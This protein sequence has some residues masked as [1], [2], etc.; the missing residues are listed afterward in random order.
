V[1]FLGGFGAPKS[2]GRKP[3]REQVLGSNGDV[4]DP[5]MGI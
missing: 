5:T 2:R 1:D 3:T 4:N